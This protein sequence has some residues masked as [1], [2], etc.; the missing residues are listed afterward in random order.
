MIDNF[1][2][3]P[4]A[5]FRGNRDYYHSTDCYTHLLEGVK[6]HTGFCCEGPIH[7]NFRRPLISMPRFTVSRTGE[8]P[9]Q[10]NNHAIDFSFVLNKE[11]VCGWVEPI[12]IPIILRQ[13]YCENFV[14]DANL[15]ENKIVVRYSDFRV[16]SIELTTALAMEL[17]RRSALKNKRCRWL[18]IRLMLLQPLNLS[19]GD[20]VAIEIIKVV[21]QRFCN[22]DVMINSKTAGTMIFMNSI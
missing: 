18:L 11:K 9:T 12:D 7:V 17:L 15:H 8:S 4:N 14:S 19:V 1:V 21:G 20:D 16:S 6:T 5:R 13:S 3:Y 2:F 10:S 22:V